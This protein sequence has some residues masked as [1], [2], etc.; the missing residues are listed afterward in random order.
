M[1]RFAVVSVTFGGL[2]AVAC[3]S[4]GDPAAPVLA[5]SAPAPLPSAGAPTW[6]RDVEPILQT[7]CTQ[8]HTTNGA[9][10]FVLDRD[11]ATAIAPFLAETV[12]DGK[13]PPW[14]PGPLSPP[15]A[16]ARTLDETSVATIVAWAAAGAPLGD[17]RD[18]VERPSRARPLPARAPDLTLAIGD[19]RAYEAPASPFATDEVRCFVMETPPA[20]GTGDARVVAARFHAGAPVG[21]HDIGAVVVG[22]EA[23]AMLRAQSGADGRAGFECAGGL[24]ER[25]TE[26]ESVLLGAHDPGSGSAAAT[27][28]PEGT[29]AAIPAGGAVVMRVHYGVKHLAGARDRSTIDLWLASAAEAPKLAVLEHLTVDAPV[30]VPCPS[31][32]ATDP[33]SPCSRENA[34]VRFASV[35]AND[36]RA[37]ADFRLGECGTKLEALTSTLA[38]ASTSAPRFLVGTTCTRASPFAGTV[39]VVRPRMLTHGA[40]IR[41]EAEQADGSWAIVVD[42]PRWRWSW[43]GAYVLERGVPIAA[44]RGL[45]VSCT[46]DNGDANQW[47]AQTGE[48]GHLG[49]ARPPWLAPSYLVAAPHRAAERCAVD[50]AVE[51]GI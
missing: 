20:L 43:A 39:R 40:S 31:G 33:S 3:S 24:F 16:D 34:F 50:V 38:F 9:G 19:P 5:A 41:V 4:T 21:V 32:L 2:V 8:C 14:P 29:A 13:M 30:E 27:I 26:L 18:H 11:T 15:I 42:V 7:A 45:R 35:L 6:Y 46:F 51:R 28:L 23:A 48:P 22:A 12:K 36:A 1:R 10:A 49:P 44:G 37:R 17:A 25:G 47:S